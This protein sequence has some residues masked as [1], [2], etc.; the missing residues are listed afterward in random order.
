MLVWVYISVSE[1]ANH[2]CTC[3]R[4]YVCMQANVCASLWG[5]A[6]AEDTDTGYYGSGYIF[7]TIRKR[8]WLHVQKYPPQGPFSMNP[9]SCTRRRKRAVEI[10]ESALRL[11]FRYFMFRVLRW[12]EEAFFS[13]SVLASALACDSVFHCSLECFSVVHLETCT[14][15]RANSFTHK[16]TSHKHTHT[17]ARKQTY[18]HLLACTHHVLTSHVYIYS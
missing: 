15:S 18:T 2:T 17:R 11:R 1:S 14:Q 4:M 9:I 16:R 7:L 6:L 5:R 3:L 13:L 12:R 8:M 10:S